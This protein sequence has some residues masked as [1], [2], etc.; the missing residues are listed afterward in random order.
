MKQLLVLSGKGGTGKTTLSAAF[1]ELLQAK[2][3]ADCDVD[4]PN[5]HLVM[6]PE[7]PGERENYS[8]MKKAIIDEE[9]C[10][11]CGVC[12]MNC[13]FEAIQQTLTQKG[14]CYEV[15]PYLCEGCS[16]CQLVCEFDAVSMNEMIDG[17]TEVFIIPNEEPTIFST[18]KLKMGSGSSGKLV[19]KVK[20]NLKSKWEDIYH[21]EKD[22]FQVG[23]LQGGTLQARTLDNE[24]AIIDGSPGIG[25]PVISS[26]SGVSVVLLVVEPTV[27]GV[28]DMKR[29]AKVAKHFSV[30]VSI[31]VNKY[32]INKRITEEI[33]DYAENNTFCFAGVI[34]YDSQVCEV[35]NQGLNVVQ[36]KLPIVP[37]I[38]QILDQTI[39]I[40]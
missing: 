37:N 13:Q 6:K 30:P 33:K 14:T 4:A 16:V 39:K 26:I 11:G 31:C 23:A 8:G 35:Q 15:N 40:I 10:S 18:A 19:T 38:Q 7:V 27:S 20:T 1:V 34:P 3:Y 32:D 28:S 25:C 9:V 29:I 12:Y 21:I 17:E 22:D 24:I 2:A 5:L 36:A